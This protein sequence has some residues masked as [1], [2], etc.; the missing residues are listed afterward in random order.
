[1]S[2]SH[3]L[4]GAAS[5]SDPI[6]PVIF[7]ITLILAAALLG[8]F[9][10]RKL[11]QPSV[12]GEL[13]MGVALGN[14]LFWFHYDLMV[15][16]REG[17]VCLDMGR[18][19][20]SGMSWPEAAVTV[21]GKEDGPR[22]LGVLRG[23]SGGEYL[24]VTQAVDIF[25]RY[26]VIF[27]LFHVGL[28][29]CVAELK[30][31]GA[32]S[33]RVAVIGVIGPFTMGFLVAWIFNPEA[34]HAEHMF[35]G[36]TLGAT[37]IGITARVLRDLGQEHSDE[38]HV[39][40]GAAVMDDVLGLI[41]LAIVSGIVVTGSVEVQEILRTMLLATLFIV[42][43][44][45]LGP[46]IIDLLIWMLRRL[47]VMEA[48]LF[49]SFIFVM[50]LAWLANLVGL[51]TIVGAFAAG[52][53]LLDRHFK[54]WG[55]HRRH[56]YTI[57]DLFAP[58]EAIMVPIFFVLMGM[59]VKLETFLH[60]EVVIM[61]AGLLVAAILGKILA[62]WGARASLKRLPIGIGMMPR[63]EVGLVFASI[64]KSLNVIDTATFSAVVM[65]VITTTLATPPLL[66][67]LLGQ[68]GGPGGAKRNR[69]P[70]PE[71]E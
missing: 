33:L 13:L 68:G 60:W 56:K 67:L 43:V 4:T 48:K 42:A 20:L 25:S 30:Q 58:L 57:K 69:S 63:G 24:Q 21:L 66:K 50:A 70:S 5:H 64:G 10:A 65:M 8:R 28:D 36:A 16:L 12:L 38:A 7:G 22:F 27:L 51:A 19:A 3:A 34:G 52:L 53:L 61:A 55:D 29:T 9:A 17:T 1:M 2:P 46:Y 37:S 26:G 59:Q 31:V 39:I 45:I 44:L 6:A 35:L 15:V 47:D 49:I 62:G 23:P 41:M 40:V 14:V 54:H 11:G 32:D 18:L 71:C